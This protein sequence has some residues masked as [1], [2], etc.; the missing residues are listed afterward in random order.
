[1]LLVKL[2]FEFKSPDFQ[3]SSVHNND[4]YFCFCVCLGLSHAWYNLY[5][6]YNVLTLQMKLYACQVQRYTFLVTKDIKC[7]W[8][9]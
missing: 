6:I 9:E 5:I 7:I 1:M 2:G 4:P 3:C 8:Q